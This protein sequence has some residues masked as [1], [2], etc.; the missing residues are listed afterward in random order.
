MIGTIRKHSKW[1]W[2]VIIV[3]IIIS[4]L[5][6]GAAPATRNGDHG[7]GNNYGT[8]YGHEVT[9]PAFTQMQKEFM[10]F[11]LLRYGEWPEKST[12]VKSEDIERGIYE[13]LLLIEKARTLGIQVSDQT[14]V[15]AASERLRSIG[16]GQPLQLSEFV[17]RVLQPEGLT[18]ADFQHFVH[19]DLVI[20]Q[21]LETF[22]L[23]GALVTPQEAALLYDHE[24]REVSAQ[25]VFFSA[26][27]FLAQVVIN[28]AAVSQF[29]TNY[30]AAYRLPDRISV[31]YVAFDV[32]N[33][34]AQSQAEWEKTNFTQYVD[35]MYRQYAGD[36]Q[37]ADAKTPEEAKAKMRA[38]LIQQRAT[39][40]ARQ[41][42]NDFA[43]ELFAMDPVKAE[44][45]AALAHKKNL[46]VHSTAPF[47]QKTGPAEFEASDDFIKKSF[48]LNADVP[49]AGPI[50]AG[51]A[52][53]V[54]SLAQQ[55][56]SEIP[57]LD[58]IHARVTQ[59]FQDQAAISLAQRAGTNFSARVTAQLAAGKT[60]AQAAIAAGQSPQILPPFALSSAEIPGY[61]DRAT[62]GQL[63]QAAFTTPIGH[64]GEFVPTADGGFVLFVQAMMPLDD[65]KKTADMPRFMEQVQHARQNEA[66]NL[67]LNAEVNREFRNVPFFQKSETAP[68]ALNQ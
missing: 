42:A 30:L 28:P 48:E 35:A 37:F 27:N 55:L 57:S 19:D 21:L 43:T 6:W 31:N 45:L 17:E 15:T 24:Y 9:Q 47:D 41:Q 62:L 51:N 26:S 18:A 39:L 22:G 66:F 25:A 2:A 34:L 8:I 12:N 14:V 40:D 32:S 60:F 29:Y 52:I 33:Y 38:L 1:L 44:N 61:D 13:R 50:A 64:A 10:I 20:E 16:R 58:S 5:W 67:W 54:F 65:T 3:A 49:Y 68:G 63:K 11:Y 59:D 4:F 56:P 46:I 7:N 23:A 53:Y 36:K